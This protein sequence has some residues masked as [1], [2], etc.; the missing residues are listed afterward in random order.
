[1]KGYADL[2]DLS[3]DERID[4][5]GRHART[6]IVGAGVE[7][8]DLAK[9]ARYIEKVTTRFPDVRHIATRPGPHPSITMLQFGP[10]LDD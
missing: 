9:Q 7:S 5:I 2:N 3:E 6:Q 8:D 4:V 10:K 1:M